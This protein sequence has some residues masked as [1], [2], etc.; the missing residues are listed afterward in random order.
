ME[1]TIPA[2]DL[3]VL[4]FDGTVT[5]L[6]HQDEQVANS[7]WAR[8]DKRILGLDQLISTRFNRD[9][10]LGKKNRGEF[11]EAHELIWLELS[12][13]AWTVCKLHRDQIA[14][15]FADN[16]PHLRPGFVDFLRWLKRPRE[17]RRVITAINS[18]GFSDIIRHILARLDAADLVDEICA[19]DMVFDN[20]GHF[21]GYEPSSL[22]ITSTKPTRT[23]AVLAKYGLT[24]DRAIGVGDSDGDALIVPEGGT[25]LLLAPHDKHARSY[26]KHFHA[27][28][29]SQDWSGPQAWLADRCGL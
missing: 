27:T 22:V 3:V 16:E 7:T 9:Y 21:V 17:N 23:A 4:D 10:F 2:T 20:D 1:Q 15:I 29:V 24:P 14:E 26:G 6:P 13:H 25:K 18:Y 11:T 5:L 19:M 12:V 28:V 8:V